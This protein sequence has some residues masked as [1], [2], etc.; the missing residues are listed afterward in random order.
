MDEMTAAELAGRIRRR[1]LSPVEVVD[2]AL[3]RIE[4]GNGRLNAFVHLD[5]EQARER[6]ARAGAAV[7]SGA[8]LGPLHG[9]PT[10]MK[11][12]FDFKPG[13]PSTFG[14]VRALRDFVPDDPGG[15]LRHLR[16][17]AVVRPASVHRA[18]E[19]VHGIA[20]VPVRGHARPNRGGRRAGDGGARR[21][22]PA[23]SVRTG[24]APFADVGAGSV[25]PRL[26]DRLQ[27]G[28]RR[29]PG[30]ARGRRRRGGRRA[31]LRGGRRPGRA[32]AARHRARPARAERSVVPVDRPDQRRHV[33]GLQAQ[34]ARPAG[35]SS[36][37]LP[38]RVPALDR[39]GL[40][41]ADA[42][43]DARRR[44]PLRDLRRDP[45]GARRPR[46][47]GHADARVPARSERRRRQ[48]SPPAWPRGCRSAC[49]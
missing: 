39:R 6:A 17:Q 41:V 2:A 22:R 46:A 47:A 11:D 8:E 7:A 45:G 31:R 36:R 27:P 33:R 28:L 15:L 23:R 16:L 12:V 49:S 35:R 21:L 25:D 24:R 38:A 20:P 42:R 44:A 48:H 34:R 3:E 40:P 37:R 18:S 4:A 30:G 5:L 29:L 43:P 14:G 19:R 1:E 10:A 13:W 32:G 9:V 26:A